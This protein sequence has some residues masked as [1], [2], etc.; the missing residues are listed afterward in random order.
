MQLGEGSPFIWK[1]P[2]R[3]DT[4]GQAISKGVLDGG[5]TWICA[6]CCQKLMRRPVVCALNMCEIQHSSLH[7][8]LYHQRLYV[9]KRASIMVPAKCAS[10]PPVILL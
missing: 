8:E 4:E 3:H 6:A 1:Y 5:L 7:T 9:L 10:S 2:C